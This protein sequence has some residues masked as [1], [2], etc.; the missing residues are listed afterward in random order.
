VEFF[1]YQSEPNALLN[2]LSN[3]L[4]SVNLSIR[5]SVNLL[6]GQ[7]VPHLINSRAGFPYR[8]STR[9]RIWSA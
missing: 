3:K 9:E 4:K 7:R 1:V 6:F 8:S 5:Q 2:E